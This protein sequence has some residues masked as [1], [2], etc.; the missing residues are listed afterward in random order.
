MRILIEINRENITHSAKIRLPRSWNSEEVSKFIESVLDALDL[1]HI[2]ETVVG[3]YTRRG[4]SG[5]QRK[6]TNIGMELVSAPVCFPF[7]SWR[8]KI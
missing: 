5:G 7:I 6:R 8:C 1:S 4:I 3:D 2:A